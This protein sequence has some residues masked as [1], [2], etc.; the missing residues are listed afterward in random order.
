[1]AF[2]EIMLI[3]GL[4]LVAYFV[5]SCLAYS[6][7]HRN[8]AAIFAMNIFF[9]WTLLGWAAAFIWALTANTETPTAPT[10]RPAWFAPVVAFA[11]TITLMILLGLMAN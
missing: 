8:R 1:M 6:R 7:N 11:G 4:A 2:G 3:I 10:A 9:G 5:P